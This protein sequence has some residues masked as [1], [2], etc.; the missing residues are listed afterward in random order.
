MGTYMGGLRRP[1]RSKVLPSGNVCLHSGNG[2]C[3]PT[4]TAI[5][6]RSAA[7]PTNMSDD[8]AHETKKLEKRDRDKFVD[9]GF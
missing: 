8:L 2:C 6:A 4:P 5:A 7:R 1:L 9:Y 3:A